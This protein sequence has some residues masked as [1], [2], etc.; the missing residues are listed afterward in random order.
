MPEPVGFEFN[1]SIKVE[2]R[3]NRLTADGGTL[4]LRELDERLR[5]TADLA[6]K[7]VDSRNP[8]F[9]THPL[10]ELLRT[11]LYAMAQGHKDQDDI[12]RLRD[13]PAFR[14][15]VS[16]RRGTSPLEEAEGLVPNGLSSQPTQSRLVES[17]SGEENLAVLNA[18]LF[19][20]AWKDLSA[21]KRGRARRRVLDVDSLPIQAHGSQPGSAKNGYYHMRCFHPIAV[22]DH[23][24]AYP[25]AAKLRPGNVSSADGVVDFLLPVIERTK[26]EGLAQYVDVRGDAGF[27]TEPLLLPLEEQGDHYA[28]R[29]ST[30]PVLE[31]LAKPYLKRP[32]GRPPF[33]PRVW[34]HELEYRVTS[35]DNP[36]S[37]S[38]RVVLVVLE[39]PGELFL[40]QFFLVTNWTAAERTGLEILEWYRQ[41][42]TME[43]YLGEFKS[44]LQPALSSAPR[45][46]THVNGKQPK[47]WQAPRDAEA[48]NEATFLLFLLAY[49][50]LNAA[51]RVMNRSARDEG[52]WS[53]DRLRTNL[54]K[55]AARVTRHSRYAV[56][57]INAAAGLLWETFRRGVARLKPQLC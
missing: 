35:G 20:W 27:P 28:F 42:G 46:K 26:A 54:L 32:P 3:G 30:N 12:D 40:E 24:S 50:L 38:R 36:W 55:V 4:L 33:E 53:L 11:R 57:Q 49:S 17:L 56:F 19:E 31:R 21:S 45:P 43:G 48:A 23:E 52:P 25:L 7:L 13:D 9:V 29:L 37:R 41:R 6:E 15:S 10:D 18:S 16:E 2:A 14:V 44:V 34:T 51:R 22:F 8:I 5:L 39:K 47:S 1:R